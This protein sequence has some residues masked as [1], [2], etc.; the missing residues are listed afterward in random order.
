[1]AFWQRIDKWAAKRDVKNL[2]K[3]LEHDDWLCRK[4]A[5]SA[6]G[7]IADPKGLGPL[8]SLLRRESDS[9]VREAARSAVAG[10]LENPAV[11]PEARD[12]ARD[13][14]RETAPPTR[15]QEASEKRAT[16]DIPLWQPGLSHELFFSNELCHDCGAPLHECRKCSGAFHESAVCNT[17]PPPGGSC[18]SV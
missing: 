10:M 9:Q 7:S 13:A 4:R 8:V 16:E 12:R 5:A 18:R 11:A 14:Y 1:M 6:L 17:F 2:I 15:R 3:A